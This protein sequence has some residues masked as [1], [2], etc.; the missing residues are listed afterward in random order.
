MRAIALLTLLA[1]C[2]LP[3]PSAHQQEVIRVL[4]ASDA[5]A[6]PIIV[7]VAIAAAPVAG[8]AAPTVI[9]TANADERMAHP[10]VVAACARFGKKPVGTVLEASP[11]R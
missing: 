9:A 3:P 2:A 6:Q 4:C 11:A 10:A 1:G 5:L 8:G 7:P